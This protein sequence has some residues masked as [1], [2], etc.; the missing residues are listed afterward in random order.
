MLARCSNPLNPTYR[1]V[2]VCDRWHDFAAFLADM[3]E[4]PEGR[5]IDRVDGTLGYFK[6]NCRWATVAEQLANRRPY[7]KRREMATA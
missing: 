6:N 3:G 1:G 7:A 2:T 5:T 4:R